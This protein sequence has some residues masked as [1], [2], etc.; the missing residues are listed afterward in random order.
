MP[1]QGDRTVAVGTKV[2]KNLSGFMQA[3]DFGCE[4]KYLYRDGKS[5]EFY[6][7]QTPGDKSQGRKLPAVP[8]L[9]DL[10]LSVVLGTVGSLLECTISKS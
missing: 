6:Y 1:A 2:R 7:M 4:V 5:Q 10:V 9:S 3:L 8:S